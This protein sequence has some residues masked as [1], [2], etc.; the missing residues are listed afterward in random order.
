LFVVRSGKVYLAVLGR[1]GQALPEAQLCLVAAQLGR[2][3]K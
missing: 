1:T 2:H 3:A